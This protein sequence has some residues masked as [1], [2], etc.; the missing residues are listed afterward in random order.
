MKII[1]TCPEIHTMTD[2]GTIKNGYVTLEDGKFT[3]VG[4]AAELTDSALEGATVI[5]ESGRLFPGFIDGHTHIGLLDDSL[6]FEGDDV[7]EAS[8]PVTPQMRGLD[9]IYTFDRCFEEAYKAG[10]TCA[11]AGPGSANTIGGQFCRR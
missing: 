1:I 5:H 3:A 6:N 10:V 8:D 9:S 4:A 7:N 11:A 2:A